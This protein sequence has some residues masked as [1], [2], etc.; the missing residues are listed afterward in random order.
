M[1]IHVR[2]KMK[3]LRLKTERKLALLIESIKSNSSHH[4]KEIEMSYLSH[5]VR[6]FLIGFRMLLAFPCCLVHGI[7]PFLFVNTASDTA[8]KILE[9]PDNSL[10]NKS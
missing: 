5:L 6:A 9:K 10:Y 7:F 2:I 4:L 8:K 3:Q 1:I